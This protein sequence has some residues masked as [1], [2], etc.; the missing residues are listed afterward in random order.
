VVLVQHLEYNTSSS[1]RNAQRVGP[2]TGARNRPASRMCAARRRC[3]ELAVRRCSLLQSPP[4]CQAPSPHLLGCDDVQ[5]LLAVLPPGDAGQPV[6]V[7]AGDVEFGGGGLNGLR[8]RSGGGGRWGCGRVGGAGESE[9][10]G[11]AGGGSA[12]RHGRACPGSTITAAESVR[13]RVFYPP[14]PTLAP[15]A[16]SPTPPRSLL[17]PPRSGAP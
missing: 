2:K 10:S 17:P 12:A 6:Q 5:L 14:T 8:A 11:G 3:L 16:A 7:V 4:C 9:R 15:P 1:G 13:V